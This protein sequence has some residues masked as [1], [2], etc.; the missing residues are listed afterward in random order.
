MRTIDTESRL[1]ALVEGAGL[2]PVHLDPWE[3]WKLFKAF[4]REAVVAD[5]EG[6]TVQATRLR[7]DDGLDLV[8][9]S[10]LRQFTA[11]EDDL[12]TP[13]WYVGL[14]LAYRS[15]DLPLAADAELWSYDFADLTAFTSEV[16][17]RPWFQR[18]LALRPV[19]TE[20]VSGEI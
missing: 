18:A 17:L 6:V 8:F 10:L 13:I 19:E 9:V 11:V 4:A 15:E 3:G 12:Q 14:E 16:E 20:I 1:A 7:S 2:D 5:D